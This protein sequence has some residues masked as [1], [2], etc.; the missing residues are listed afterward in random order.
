MQKIP[1]EFTGKIRLVVTPMHGRKVTIR[2]IDTET[3]EQIWAETCEP[4][5]GG[6]FMSSVM[7]EGEFKLGGGYMVD[8]QGKKHH[9]IQAEPGILG[10]VLG[11]R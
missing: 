2:W 5:E 1:Q 7:C 6:S 9:F 4:P 11:G 8:S 3:N 10:Q